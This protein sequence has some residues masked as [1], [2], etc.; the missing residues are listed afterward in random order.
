M[1]GLLEGKCAV[2]AGGGRGIGREVAL[3]MAR[4]GAKV[5]VND[6]GTELN[7]TGRDSAPAE[8]VVAEIRKSGGKA[9]ASFASVADFAAAGRWSMPASGSS[10]ESTS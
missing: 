4:H 3:A 9:I 1:T 7:G 6:T 2:I 5:V 8:E 10:A